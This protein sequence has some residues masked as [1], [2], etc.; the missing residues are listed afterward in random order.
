MTLSGTRLSY[1]GQMMNKIKNKLWPE[2]RQVEEAPQPVHASQGHTRYSMV[3]A[4]IVKHDISVY[5]RGLE[6]YR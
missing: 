2:C 5:I 4:V 6:K 3:W 1:S